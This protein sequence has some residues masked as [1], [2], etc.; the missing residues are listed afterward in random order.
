MSESKFDIWDV[1]MRQ[2]GKLIGAFVISLLGSIALFRAEPSD[3]PKIIGAIFSSTTTC[4][5]GWLVALLIFLFSV[6]L[7]TIL[8]KI[9]PAE[10][11]RIARER[12]KYQEIVLGKKVQHSE[13]E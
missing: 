13:P 8:L 3:V 10:M 4:W 11:K 5:V 6:I 7:V 1:L 2:G 9:Y 12:D